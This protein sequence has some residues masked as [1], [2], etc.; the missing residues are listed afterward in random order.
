MPPI[1]E[2]WTLNYYKT[3]SFGTG[4]RNGQHSNLQFFF[5][6]F[7]VYRISNPLHHFSIVAPN[8]RQCPG[9]GTTSETAKAAGCVLAINAGFFNRSTG[10]CI[11]NVVSHGH[12]VEISGIENVNFAL[13]KVNFFSSGTGAAYVLKIFPLL[14]WVIPCRLHYSRNGLERRGAIFRAD[15]WYYSA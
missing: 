6:L 7:P 2:S 5:F 13:L 10:D 4:Q 12:R 9:Y 15:L 8:N 14:E 11:G 1:I 3:R